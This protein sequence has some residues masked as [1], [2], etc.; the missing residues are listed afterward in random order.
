[1]AKK[2]CKAPGCVNYRE[3]GSNYCLKHR[4]R[5][6]DWWKKFP[7]TPW[8]DLYRSPEWIELRREVLNE[9]PTCPCGAKATEV[10]HIIPHRGNLELFFNKDNLIGLC[11]KCHCIET[12]KEIKERRNERRIEED[13]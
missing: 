10:H 1:M 4:D 3:E 11:H 12:S 8:N 5:E 13:Y 7:D 2:M 9:Q 6:V